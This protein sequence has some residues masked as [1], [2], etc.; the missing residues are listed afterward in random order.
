[1][2]HMI[3]YKGFHDL[4]PFWGAKFPVAMMAQYYVKEPVLQVYGKTRFEG[5]D[6][7]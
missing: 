3:D 6:S 1:M 7:V 5:G 2:I 4:R